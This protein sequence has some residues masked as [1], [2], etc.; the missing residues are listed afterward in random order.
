[1]VFFHDVG[2]PYERRDM[3][4]Q[5]DTIPVD[6][7]QKYERKGIIKD[8]VRWWITGAATR[9]SATPFT[10]VDYKTAY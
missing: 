6:F 1:M 5:P 3:Y 4:Y 9:K 10:K 8:K 2:W 7:L